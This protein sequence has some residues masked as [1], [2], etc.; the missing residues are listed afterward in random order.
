MRGWHDNKQGTTKSLPQV[1]KAVNVVENFGT[2]RT[3]PSLLSIPPG[4]HPCLAAALAL[5]SKCCVC[6]VYYYGRSSCDTQYVV[7]LAVECTP[8]DT[9]PRPCE[10]LLVP[11]G[12]PA[13]TGVWKQTVENSM[14]T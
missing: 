4:R 1:F 12:Q 11:F 3:N 14:H 6:N 13:M 7:V 10:D 2:T 5:V 8:K 9:H